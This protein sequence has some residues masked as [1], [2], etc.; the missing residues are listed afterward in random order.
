MY[1]RVA[2]DK[3]ARLWK[4][5]SPSGPTVDIKDKTFTGKVK[6]GL[7]GRIQKDTS[8]YHFSKHAASLIKDSI[9]S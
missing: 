8:N 2:K 6:S 1:N 7:V 4:D 9:S 3:K 5:Y